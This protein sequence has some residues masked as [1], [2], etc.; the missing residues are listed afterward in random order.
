MKPFLTEDEKL[1][2]YVVG[3]LKRTLMQ[4]AEIQLSLCN[5]IIEL[6]KKCINEFKV[7][8]FLTDGDK[9]RRVCGRRIEKEFNIN[10]KT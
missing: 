8:P 1:K 5:R 9:F 7:E 10:G 3:K 2:M 6:Y 4:M